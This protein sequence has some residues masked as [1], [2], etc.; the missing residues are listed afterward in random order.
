MTFDDGLRAL[1]ARGFCF[2][3][4]KDDAGNIVVLVGSYGW[5]DHYDRIHIYS[6]DEAAAARAL[7]DTRPGADE[8]VWS[9]EGDAITS[10]QELLNLP[11][12]HEPGAPRLVRRAPLGL[13]LP[14]TERLPFEP[15]T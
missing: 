15:P 3:H 1:I 4:L 6:Q 8:V 2:Q 12:P 5:Q 10:I 7:I 13:W 9:Y 14:E 11:K